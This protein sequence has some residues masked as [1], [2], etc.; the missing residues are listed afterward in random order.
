MSVD[1][2]D[3]RRPKASAPLYV[4]IIL[5]LPGAKHKGQR[6]FLHRQHKGG[7]GQYCDRV[8]RPNRY[9]QI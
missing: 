8:A 4:L 3:A 9:L 5:C 1:F 7:S 2:R 6:E